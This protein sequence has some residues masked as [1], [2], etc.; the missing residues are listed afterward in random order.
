MHFSLVLAKYDW[1]GKLGEK[2]TFS[3]WEWFPLL[4]VHME[5]KL[6]LVPKLITDGHEGS[7]DFIKKKK[8]KANL[9]TLNKQCKI[10]MSLKAN[11]YSIQILYSV[12]GNA[13]LM[14]CA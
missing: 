4:A 2:G 11:R 7:F 6:C 5:K 13:L 12:C 9:C 8:N 14:Y 3:N 1:I 10:L